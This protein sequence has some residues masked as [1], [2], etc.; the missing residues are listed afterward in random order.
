MPINFK[1]TAQRNMRRT[2]APT[3]MELTKRKR[4]L[5]TKKPEIRNQFLEWNRD[6]ELYAFNQRLSEKFDMDS[7]E[8]SLT[9]RSLANKNK[10]KSN[11]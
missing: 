1:T 9:H 5:K 10:L 8:R 6:S 3:L 7:L 11:N 4:A 2:L